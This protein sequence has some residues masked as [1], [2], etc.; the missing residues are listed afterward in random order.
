MWLSEGCA[1]YFGALFFEQSDGRDDFIE[2][3]EKSKNRIF[4][5][6]ATNRPIVDY[7]VR[8]LFKLLNSNNYPKGAWVLH[9]LRGLLGDEV[10]FKGISKYYSEYNNKTALTNDFMKIME[11]VSG[12][13]LKYF[14]DQWIF[15]PGYPIIESSNK[16]GFLKITVKAK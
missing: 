8:D 3:M 16:I 4:Q 12:K 1:T 6:K 2:R 5:S 15:R 7:E 14:F 10:F 9:M 13:N 11:E